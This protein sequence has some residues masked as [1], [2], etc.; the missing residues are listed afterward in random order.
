MGIF[1]GVLICSDIDGTLTANGGVPEENVKYIKY[2][3]ENGGLFTISTGRYPQFIFE[4]NFGFEPNTYAVVVNGTVISS[5]DEK[6]IVYDVKLPKEFAKEVVDFVKAGW[7]G[8]KYRACDM[9]HQE[10]IL[11]APVDYDTNKLVFI[12][13]DE[14]TA[15]EI[16]SALGKKLDGIAHVSRSWPVGVEVIPYGSGK[17]EC[18]KKLKEITGSKLLICVGDF[19][20]DIDMIKSA[21]IGYAVDNASDL[22]KSVAD[23]ITVA[24]DKS[25]IAEIIKTTE[26]ELKKVRD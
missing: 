2:F 18:V 11:D 10:N 19:E 12:A 20:N 25:A 1:D 16:L 13:E 14:N 26:M 22:V 8:V 15:I 4:N 6:E 7:S 17:G 23:R 3:M 5:F 24:N 21:D 9:L